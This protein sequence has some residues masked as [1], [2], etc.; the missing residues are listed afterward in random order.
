MHLISTAKQ[1]VLS[2]FADLETKSTYVHANGETT[3]FQFN[4]QKK[5]FVE[6]E[7]TTGLA[8]MRIKEKQEKAPEIQ[9]V[10]KLTIDNAFCVGCAKQSLEEIAV[11]QSTGF[12]KLY[13]YRTAQLIHRFPADQPRSTVLY[14]D[15]N[16]TDEYIAAVRE[17]GSINIY[18]T[19]T[20]NKI[21]TLTFDDNATL[22]RFHPAKRFQ[23]SVASYKGAVTVYDMQYKRKLL[24][25]NDAHDAPCR[26]ISMCSAQP[27][28]LVSVGY[29]CKINIFD[30][31]RRVQAPSGRLSYSHPLSTVALSECGTYF[32]AGNLKGE[33]IAYD[34]RSTKSPLAVRNVHE[35][36]V[37]RIAFVPMSKEDYSSSSLSSS[38]VNVTVE[39]ETPGTVSTVK[40]VQV[41]EAVPTGC[42]DLRKSIAANLLSTQQQLEAMSSSIGYASIMAT[43]AAPR[44]QRDSFCDFFDAQGYRHLERVSTRFSQRRDSFDWETLNRRPSNEE[45]R[46]SICQIG[47]GLTSLDS[48]NS[49]SGESSDGSKLQQTLSG[50]LRDRSNISGEAKLQQI[51]ETDEQS[52]NCSLTSSTGTGSDKENPQQVDLDLKRHLRLLSA[53]RNSTPHHVKCTPL[54]QPQQLLPKSSSGLTASSV[55]ALECNTDVRKELGE[56]REYF[57][58]RFNQM[59]REF[60]FV[61]E[62]NKWEIFTQASNYWNHQIDN[63]REIRDALAMLLQTDQFTQEF[64]RLQLENDMLKA[65]L[66]KIEQEREE[67]E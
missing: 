4:A 51:A 67:K 27:A 43:P 23:L 3:D 64:V 30:I 60:K 28:L 9:R 45:Q 20:K 32:C 66:Q 55:S 42:D 33:L 41:L 1:T 34:M 62:K 12:V 48:A 40:P 39:A 6:V 25:I 61:S 5:V 10:R 46:Q 7:K 2:D 17:S 19:K 65:Q 37:T 47:S 58:E 53:S 36:A 21:E 8:V 50:P 35:C 49:S 13:N 22:A 24:N 54:S 15:Y 44:A 57:E 52:A 63:T 14:V 31:R 38:N 56:M 16:S 26:D 11:G 18:G 59:E 29:D